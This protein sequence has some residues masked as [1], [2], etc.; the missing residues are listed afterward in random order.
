MIIGTSTRHDDVIFL[1]SLEC[2]YGSYF[3][4]LQQN[5][6][7]CQGGVAGHCVLNITSL[8]LDL[9]IAAAKF[10]ITTKTHKCE[11]ITFFDEFVPDTRWHEVIH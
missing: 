4:T 6:Y 7:S 10:L 3:N 1:S 8:I 11:K 2:I 9:S 5:S